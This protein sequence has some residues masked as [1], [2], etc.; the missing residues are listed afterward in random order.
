MNSGISARS[1]MA[2]SRSGARWSS[3]TMITGGSSVTMRWMR[4]SST[5]G[6]ASLR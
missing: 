5:S 1:H 3:A 4:R 2:T 6:G